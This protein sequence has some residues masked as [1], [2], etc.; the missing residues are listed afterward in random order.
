M[1]IV[2]IIMMAEESC[3][4][5]DYQQAANIIMEN[6]ISET[7]MFLSKKYELNETEKQELELLVKILQKIYNNSG[8]YTGR[9]SKS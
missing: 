6:N 5:G 8:L 1:S 3:N 9:A 2:D 7:C 4:L